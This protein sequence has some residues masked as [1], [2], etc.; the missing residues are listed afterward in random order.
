[1]SG[2]T[3]GPWKQQAERQA[4]LVAAIRIKA[5]GATIAYVAGDDTVEDVKG[6]I[7]ERVSDEASANARLVAA[8]PDLLDAL[9]TML[10]YATKADSKAVAKARAAIAKAEGQS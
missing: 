5:E 3:P 10:T 6:R 2:H 4:G 8:A 1:V 7:W 9:R